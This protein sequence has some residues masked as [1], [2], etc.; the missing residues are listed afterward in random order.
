[1]TWLDRLSWMPVP[2]T[3][4]APAVDH[5]PLRMDWV[6]GAAPCPDKPLISTRN[7][8]GNSA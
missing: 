2:A 8:P 4:N 5:E 1:M 6:T 7:A 3:D